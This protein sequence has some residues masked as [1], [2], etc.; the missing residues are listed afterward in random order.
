LLDSELEIEVGHIIARLAEV[1]VESAS[2]L[3]CRREVLKKIEAKYP[4]GHAYAET[5]K[6]D[7]DTA[8]TN[9]WHKMQNEWNNRETSTEHNQ[10]TFWE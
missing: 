4:K 2:A 9:F 7:L 10:K 3:R 5:L 1:P 6:N 8:M